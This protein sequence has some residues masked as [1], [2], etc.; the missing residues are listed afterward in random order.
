VRFGRLALSRRERGQVVVLFALLLPMILGIGSIVVTIGN[1]YVHKK[2]LQT[3]VDAGAFASGQEFTGCFQDPAGTNADIAT[4]ALK[5]AG[6]PT[7]DATTENLQ[8]EDPQDAHVVLNSSVYWT[9][10]PYPADDTLGT[11]CAVKFLDVKSTEDK[12]P[13]LFRWL[14]ASPSPKTH[15]RIQINRALGASGVL[16]VAVPEVFPDKVAALFVNESSD[17][18]VGG[19]NLNA[20]SP[21]GLSA[22]NVYQGDVGGVNLGVSGEYD[23]VIVSSRDASFI[24]PTSGTL[25]SVCN[26]DPVQT[27]CY[28]KPWTS[29]SNRVYVIHAYSGATAGGKNPPA[30]RQVELNG[31]C[32]TDLSRAYFNLDAGCSIAVSAHIDFGNGGGDPTQP[33]SPICAKA[34]VNG[35]PM[36]WGTYAGDPYGRWTGSI[37]P[38]SGSGRNNVTITW[39]TDQAPPNCGGLKWSGSFGNTG[40]AYA[41]NTN[42]GAV[43]YLT[44]MDNATGLAAGSINKT[45]SASLH[46]TVGLL[47]PVNEANALDAPIALRFA[48]TAGSQNQAVD[49]DKNV[50]FREELI[51]DCQNPYIENARNGSCAGY[52][53]GNL[54]QPPIGPLP[55]DDCVVTETGDKSGQIRQAMDERFGRNGGPTCQTLN[56]WPSDLGEL[57]DPGMPD[58]LTDPRFVTIFITDEQAFGASG[59]QVY[60]VR[61]FAGFYL[62]AADGLNCPGDVPANPGSKNMWGHWVSYVTSENGGIPDDELCPFTNGGLCIPVL[63]E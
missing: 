53:T 3:L 56:H 20:A 32:P 61:R 4:A 39:E 29:L 42:S 18:I 6:D 58:P 43:Q 59:N 22:F 63:V 37:S 1:W 55:G 40:S 28:G 60:P 17:T 19:A 34:W 7:R 27:I 54:P 31:G 62:T 36:T 9:G 52:S 5:Y 14:P 51:N 24:A 45:S 35:S 38:A 11:P 47:Q 21:P 33:A 15:A 23:V 30:L 57:A 48:S 46:V 50:I 16:P 10:N 44:V 25:A 2:H 26:A 41:S 8:L 49:C 12:V 13:L